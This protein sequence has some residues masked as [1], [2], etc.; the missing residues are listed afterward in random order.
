[1]SGSVNVA[2][3][4]ERAGADPNAPEG[5]QGWA[6]AQVDAAVAELI[7]ERDALKGCWETLAQACEVVPQGSL[8]TEFVRDA[9]HQAVA[10]AA[11]ALAR[12]QGGAA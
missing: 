11:D 8:S 2:G 12:V 4:L 5:S 6:L 7:A 10:A 9:L 1:M 3:I